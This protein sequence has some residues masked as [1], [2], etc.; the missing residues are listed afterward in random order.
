MKLTMVFPMVAGNKRIQNPNG[1]KI[2]RKISAISRRPAGKH[3]MI[4]AGSVLMFVAFGVVAQAGYCADPSSKANNSGNAV[5]VHDKNAIQV[6]E[7]FRNKMTELDNKIYATQVELA[8][9]LSDF[10]EVPETEGTKEECSKAGGTLAEAMKNTVYSENSQS[11]IKEKQIEVCQHLV[12]VRNARRN[13]L[14]GMI[15]GLTNRRETLKKI[16]DDTVR[17]GQFDWNFQAFQSMMQY[18]IAYGQQALATY[19]AQTGFLNHQQDRLAK[20]ALNGDPN[21]QSGLL[22]LVSSLAQSSLLKIALDNAQ[23]SQ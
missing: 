1:D 8:K 5:S 9:G 10:K 16:Y 20:A 7:D 18:D 19:D 17:A 6:L 3:R 13:A 14:V 2:M 12:I 23:V 4:R 15:K 21:K 22:D 11:V